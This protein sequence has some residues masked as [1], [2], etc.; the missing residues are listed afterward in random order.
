MPLRFF[1]ILVL[2]S[3]AA[4]QPW[5]ETYEKR[6]ISVK[7]I[8]PSSLAVSNS[9]LYIVDAR[10]KS[11]ESIRCV[12]LQTNRISTLRTKE[13]LSLISGLAIDSAGD[14]VVCE[15]TTARISKI[16]GHDGSVVRV[17]GGNGMGFSG[18]GGPAIIAKLS[19]P[20]NP[21]FDRHGN[22][23]FADLGNHRIRKIDSQGII[24]TIAG[25]GKIETSG[26][27]GPATRAGLEYPNA[28]AVDADG[29]ILISQYGYGSDSH[30]IRKVDAS[31]GLIDTIAGL[32]GS[33]LAGDTGP[34]LSAKLQC[35]SHVLFDLNRNILIVDPV[36]DR[37]RR[38]DAHS[39]IINSIVGTTKGFS[40]DGGPAQK[41]ELNNPAA[42][43]IDEY[44]NLYIAD[45]VN[46]RVRRVDAT[47][48]VITTIA[49]NGRG[50]RPV[51]HPVNL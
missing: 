5:Q 15:F 49:G 42:I 29:N 6:A 22:L 51:K 8:W 35:P 28:V 20:E 50:R 43:A 13:Q 24:T 9:I 41:A 47:S 45:F 46:N 23:Y 3:T 33:G 2:I 12:N 7:V 32:G 34:A 37:I 14:L 21:F 30:R 44:G 25:N 26:D 19:R 11:G 39:Q 16:N 18:D 40:G 27:G 17:A 31:T 38:I 4:Y 1:A 48:G 36:N 10:K